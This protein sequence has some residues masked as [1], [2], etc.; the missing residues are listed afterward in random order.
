MH[1]PF[2]HILG[3][4]LLTTGVASMKC[5]LDVSLVRPSRH[6]RVEPIVWSIT[7]IASIE[8]AY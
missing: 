4:V 3:R 7:V 5:V 8:I 1:E 2:D 6:T